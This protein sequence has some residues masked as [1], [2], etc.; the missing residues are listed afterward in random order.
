[1]R[2]Q[3]HSSGLPPSAAFP[4][5]VRDSG[6]SEICDFGAEKNFKTSWSNDIELEVTPTKDILMSQ[7][8]SLGVWR[9]TIPKSNGSELL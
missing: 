1:M 9:K 8:F 2:V 5:T 4:V 6:Q 7:S 3:R